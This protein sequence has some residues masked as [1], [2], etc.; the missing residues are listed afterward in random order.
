[1][2]AQF[3]A[4][5]VA[6]RAGVDPADAARRLGLSGIEFTGAVPVALRLPEKQAA[7]LEEA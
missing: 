4:L 3:D 1:M 6:V 7:S 5:G 2:K